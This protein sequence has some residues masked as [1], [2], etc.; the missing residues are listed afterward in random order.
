MVEF[1]LTFP[2][3]M[4]L[5][6]A[7]FDFSRLS[8]TYVNLLNA[9]RE[10]ARVATFSASST[11]TI[12]AA[13]NQQLIYLGA[14]ASTDQVIITVADGVCANK[15]LT[16][17]G[18]TLAVQCTGSTVYGNGGIY[19]TVTCTGL[20]LNMSSGCT[21]KSGAATTSFP[22]RSTMGN[23]YI[24]IT[25]T[26]TFTLSP[27]FDAFLALAKRATGAPLSFNLN[28]STRAYIE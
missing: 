11:S 3:F 4:V 5:L 21:D 9:A 27:F 14:P 20:P 17:P 25:V 10:M 6:M 23:G 24:D 15:M 2:L 1:A 26:S 18:S 22:S 8:F 7:L 12:Q 28:T 19:S 16:T 13:F